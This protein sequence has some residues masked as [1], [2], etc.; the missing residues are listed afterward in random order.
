VTPTIVVPIKSHSQRLKDKNFVSL[1][2]SPL[3]R[4]TLDSLKETTAPIIVAC[5]H[6]E[7]RK[8]AESYGYAAIDRPPE[9]DH[10]TAWD[11]ALHATDAEHVGLALVTC[12][13]R[14]AF[15][16]NSAI[17]QY[18]DSVIRVQL[19][20]KPLSDLSRPVLSAFRVNHRS[21]IYDRGHDDTRGLDA[22]SCYVTTGVIQIAHR[23]DVVDGHVM[24]EGSQVYEVP[25]LVGLD[26][27]TPLDW[28]AAFGAV[29]SKRREKLMEA[30]A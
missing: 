18:C 13:F 25:H 23:S 12:P 22:S 29:E 19:L 21:V 24:R 30:V 7:I 8:E 27:D 26:I 15:D 10:G 5:N 17:E 14:R 6:P 16:V 1:G 20:G 3:Y 11:V 9:W 2:G 4:W 28:C